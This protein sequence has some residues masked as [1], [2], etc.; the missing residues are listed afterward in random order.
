MN[1]DLP[2]I[3]EGISFSRGGYTGTS[4]TS[5]SNSVIQNS[6]ASS[7]SQNETLPELI[8]RV[9][10]SLDENTAATDRLM[11]WRPAVAVE[12]YEKH[13]NQYYDIKKHS[14]L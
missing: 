4:K 1:I 13:R 2:A 12:T 8:D 7:S 5:N 10:R 11:K 6:S 14:G 9:G 3:L